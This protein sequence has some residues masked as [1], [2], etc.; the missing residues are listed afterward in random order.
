MRSIPLAMTWELLIGGRW[1]LLAFALGANLFPLL[2]LSALRLEGGV[3]P[4][5]PSMLV[6]HFILVQFN[7]FTFGAAM[8]DAR[9]QPS[10]L[11]ALPIPTSSIVGWQMLLAMLLVASEI[12]ASTVCLNAMFGLGWPLWGPAL[13]AA[14]GV[15]GFQ[16]AFWSTEKSA[17]QPL[18][19][20]AV[21]VV[22][23]LWF[24]SRVGPMFS[25]PDRL[26]IEFTPGDV[27]ELLAFAGISYFA[28][29]VGVNRRRCGEAL[30]S[31][32]IVDGIKRVFDRPPDAG[33]PF[34]TP[35]QAQLWFE[36]RNKGWAFPA[37]AMFGLVGGVGIWSVFNREAQSLFEG[38][39]A[40]GVLLMQMSCIG[41]SQGIVGPNDT[42]LEM[43]HFLATRPLTITEMSRTFLKVIARSVL[44]A[45]SLWAIPFVVLT[46]IL[47][48][49]QAIPHVGLLETWGWRILPGTL[50]G[51]WTIASVLAS[52]AMTG[53]SKLMI[54]LACGL[55]ACMIGLMMF[56]RHALP[57]GSQMTF[58]RGIGISLGLA[59]ALG[60]AWMFVAARRRGLIGSPT[61]AGALGVWVLLSGFVVIDW[62]LHPARHPMLGVLAVCFATLVVAPLAAAPL[63]LAWNRNR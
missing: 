60:T 53:R 41:F 63:A 28:A 59:I 58:D 2:L 5:D 10:R 21:A 27:L 31:L 3:A 38:F 11:F 17:W 37:L 40:G 6:L 48:S 18:A 46:G 16:A 30:P 15:T 23:G 61:V 25:A 33:A 22:L 7:M 9:A 50:L 8:L 39:V 54:Q 43:G 51:C 57:R 44:I 42:T 24:K 45:W 4:S 19:V 20:T 14:A 56:S 36:W 47:F 13:F 12:L 35:A 52:I 32:G 34:A 55:F 26:W 1:T 62:V 29:V 49:Q